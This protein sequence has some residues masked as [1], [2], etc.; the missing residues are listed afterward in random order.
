MTLYVHIT[1]NGADIAVEFPD[2]SSV[3]FVE[4]KMRSTYGVLNGTVSSSPDRTA[5]VVG[6]VS[7]S[8]YY[9]RDYDIPNQNL[10][11]LCLIFE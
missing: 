4:S 5:I 1:K 2:D 8:H 7:G 11:T 10:G 3:D 9:F 6:F